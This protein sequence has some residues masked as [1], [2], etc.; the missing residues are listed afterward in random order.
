M[1]TGDGPAECVINISE[2]RDLAVVAAVAKAAGTTL[3]DVHTD[4]DHHRS[5]LTLVGTLSEVEEAARAVATAATERID[6]TAHEGV[7]PRLG[8][9]DV[10]PFVPLADPGGPTTTWE[11]AT[12][13]RDAF[14]AWAGAAL[15]LP[16]FLYGPERTLP[17]VRRRAFRD[18]AP[19]AGPPAPHPSAGAAAV[20]VRGVLIA[21]N[22]WLAADRAASPGG[23]DV[24]AVARDIAAGLRSPILRTLGLAVE[25]G[26]QVSCNVIDPSAVDLA[27]VYD[28]VAAGAAAAGCRA[29]RGELVGLAPR[30]ALDAVPEERWEQLGLSERTTIEAGRS[31]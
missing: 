8:A 12:A 29:V 31:R 2:G 21:W 28:A 30:S 19:D 4:A 14:A 7:H 11:E 24:V 18:L 1:S 9:V 23:A 15:A 26:A 22:V 25:G 16:C 5:V 10:V 27:D 6:L 17:E 20:G 13:A 3:A